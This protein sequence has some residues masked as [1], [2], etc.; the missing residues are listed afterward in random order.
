MVNSQIICI[1]RPA[2]VWETPELY[3]ESLSLSLIAA[4]EP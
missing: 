2:G 4:G 1:L 3:L